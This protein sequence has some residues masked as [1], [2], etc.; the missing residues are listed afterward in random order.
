MC[1]LFLKTYFDTYEAHPCFR[2]SFWR[3]KLKKE[4]Q[5]PGQEDECKDEAADVVWLW[6]IDETSTAAH[7]AYK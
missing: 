1:Q 6:H 5:K 2:K 4:D 3:R 7:L